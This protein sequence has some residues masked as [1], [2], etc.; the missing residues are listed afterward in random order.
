M[1]PCLV[2]QR[3]FSLIGRVLLALIFVLSGF[4]KIGAFSA[5][6]AFMASK[7]LPIPAVLLV[8]AIAIELGGGLM[9]IAG[10]HAR[11]A[12]LVLFLFIIP[13]TLIFHNFWAADPGEYQAQFINFMKNLSIMG[14][15]LF[16]AAYGPGPLSLGQDRCSQERNRH[17]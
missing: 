7:G 17:N 11:I 12:A 10:W 15:M 5:T 2:A 6:A 1:N 4:N 16:V 13:T 8:P 3:Y 9:L 14:G